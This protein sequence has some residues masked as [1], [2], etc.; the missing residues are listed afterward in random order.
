MCAGSELKPRRKSSVTASSNCSSRAC[1]AAS[2]MYTPLGHVTPSRS[3][4]PFKSAKR[5]SCSSRRQARASRATQGIQQRHT[6]ACEWLQAYAG[7]VVGQR[8][9][10]D[11]ELSQL[12]LPLDELP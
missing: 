11:A 2:V 12:H 3:A 7:L 10:G 9:A 8:A 1:L 6:R 4:K 5:R